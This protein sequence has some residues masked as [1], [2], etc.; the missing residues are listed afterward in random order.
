MLTFTR[1]AYNEANVIVMIQ[2]KAV[3]SEATS[4]G[5]FTS[6]GELIADHP[7]AVIITLLMLIGAAGTAGYSVRLQS[8]EEVEDGILVAELEDKD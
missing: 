2:P 3:E 6:F 4:N 1:A 5:F 7:F 8:R